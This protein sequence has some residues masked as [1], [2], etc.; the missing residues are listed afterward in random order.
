M[1][2][3]EYISVIQ[4]LGQHNQYY[5]MLRYARQASESYPTNEDL[6][7]LLS[8]SLFLTNQTREAT[9]EISELSD[10]S[11]NILPALIVQSLLNK[12][13]SDLET[14]IKE[15][16]L[17]AQ[18]SAL[19]LASTLYLILNKP[20]LAKE[21][22]DKAYKSD[23]LSHSICIVKGWCELESNSEGRPTTDYFSIVL[24][25]DGKSFGALLGAAKVQEQ[26]REHE[27]V[28]AILNKLIVRYPQLSVP[29]VEKLA[30]QLALKDWDQ[31]IE[32]T[33]RILNLE[34][35][36]IEA[37]KANT[38]VALCRDGN[39]S[40]GAQCLKQLFKTMN[41]REPKN[42]TLLV[43]CTSLFSKLSNS[44]EMVI[45]ELF[46]AT[47]KML[48]QQ[49]K[50]SDPE[51]LIEHANLCLKMGNLKEAETWYRSTVMMDES[52]FP[53]LIGLAQCQ[54]MDT[55]P[56]AGEVALQQVELLL[57][58][59]QSNSK[60]APELYTMSA[61]L[62]QKKDSVKAFGFLEKA[63][64]I[65][66]EAC[67]KLAYGYRYL[68]QLNPD[69]CSKIVQEYLVHLPSQLSN[70]PGK[71][72]SCL[73]I[74]EMLA[75]ACPGFSD[76][77]LVLA[78]V[79]MQLGDHE[80]AKDSLRKLL[81]DD[82]TNASGY[83][84][85]AQ[86]LARQGN[87]HQA[88]QTLESGVSCN[89]KVRDDPMYHAIT[90]AIVRERGDYEGSLEHYINAIAGI[91]KMNEFSVSDRTTVY[92]ELIEVYSK[93]KRFEDAVGLMEEAKVEL[94]NSSEEGRIV[95]SNAELALEMGDV[96]KAIFYLNQV[97]PD[98]NYFLQARIKLAEIYLNHRKDRTKFAQCYR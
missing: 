77:L 58:I 55:S 48:Q 96:D 50:S 22:A 65:I 15:Y 36:N 34:S 2:A 66:R 62:F 86:I 37:L 95:I 4:W 14:K 13:V 83:L 78:K 1:E 39:F 42:V 60:T 51:L 75:E 97:T 44:N 17:K 70:D 16:R 69:L 18:P 23:P 93:L 52:S 74:L 57:E 28:I 90:G 76:T 49:G 54:L 5:E 41:Q 24:K 9:K 92:L 6:R 27:E 59:Q 67:S 33:Q 64:R 53:A 19:G 8:L 43:S 46:R 98:A 88:A 68:D 81:E 91:K 30:N 31:V 38:L 3:T 63:A 26:I 35:Y 11:K 29:L 56:G 72:N 47:E 82:P 89:F 94:A 40:K 80:G 32:T 87:H 45:S 85:M 12:S 10:R 25:E 84:L 20:T 21:Y 73:S 79:R 61:N 71:D 7:I